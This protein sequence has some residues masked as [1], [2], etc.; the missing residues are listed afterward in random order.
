MAKVKAD[1]S[2]NDVDQ[3]LDAVK[4]ARADLKAQ[5]ELPAGQAAR[6][7]Q[8]RQIRDGQTAPP[9][10]PTSTAVELSQGIRTIFAG[11]AGMSVSGNASYLRTL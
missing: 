10:E 5:A 6:A 8:S 3:A 11:H 9:G 4:S 7:G 2:D 1:A